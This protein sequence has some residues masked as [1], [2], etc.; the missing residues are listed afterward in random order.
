MSNTEK[1][2]GYALVGT[3]SLIVAGRYGISSFKKEVLDAII[4]RFG[5]ERATTDQTGSKVTE[6]HAPAALFLFT[7]IGASSECQS[8]S[9][10]EAGARGDRLGCG[11][12]QVFRI[13]SYGS[14]GVTRHQNEDGS[15]F[16][17]YDAASTLS[18]RQG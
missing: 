12:S 10:S 11:G 5:G 1:C 4:R 2:F 13:M 8:G 15:D 16:D 9:R 7:L 14:T 17:E 18:K 6:I 3:D